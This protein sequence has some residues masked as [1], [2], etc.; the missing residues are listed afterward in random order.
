MRPYMNEEFHH[1]KNR[2]PTKRRTDDCMQQREGGV[3]DLQNRFIA[4]GWTQFLI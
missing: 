2:T 3:D 1:K 4:F